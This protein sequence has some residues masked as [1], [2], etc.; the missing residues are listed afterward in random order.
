MAGQGLLQSVRVIESSMLGPAELG[1]LLADLGADV[2]KVEPPQGDY[3][4]QM[5]W[6][7]VKASD[8][9]GENSLLSLHVSTPEDAGYLRVT[10]RQEG[11]RTRTWLSQTPRGREALARHRDVLNRMATAPG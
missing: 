9:N 7:I 5:T 6:P 4:R 3:G 8:G 10:K 2:I 1:S 11:R